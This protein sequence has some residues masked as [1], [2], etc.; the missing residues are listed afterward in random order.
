MEGLTGMEFVIRCHSIFQNFFNKEIISWRLNIME[1]PEVYISY[2]YPYPV[3]DLREKL[4][5]YAQ[6]QSLDSQK[7]R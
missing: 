4:S 6:F 2:A 3:F 7:I 1:I 5:N